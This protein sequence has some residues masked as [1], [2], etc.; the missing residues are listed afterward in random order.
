MGVCGAGPAEG[1]WG[2]G[3]DRHEIRRVGTAPGEGLRRRSRRSPL[4]DEGAPLRVTLRVDRSLVI[5]NVLAL[6]EHLRR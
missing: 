6:L 1:V 2:V 3:S 4:G 5:P